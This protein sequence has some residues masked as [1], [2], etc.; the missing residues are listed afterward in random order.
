MREKDK[1]KRR[2][3]EKEESRKELRILYNKKV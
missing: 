1:I 2:K 3:K